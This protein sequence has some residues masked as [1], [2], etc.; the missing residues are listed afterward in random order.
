[1]VL[2]FLL[3]SA[4]AAR[5]ADKA[6]HAPDAPLVK[7]A[8]AKFPNLTRAERALLEFADKSNIGRGE[9][10][11]AGISAAPLDPSNDP[12]NAAAW[13]H[14]RDIRAALLGWLA[15]DQGAVLQV[16]PNGVRVLG[17]R[18]V[19]PIDF[20]HVRVPF[21]IALI[22]CS[23]PDPMNLES[24]ELPFIDLD[25]SHTGPINAM[26]LIVHGNLNFGNSGPDRGEFSASGWVNLVYA[27]IEGWANFAGG[28]FRYSESNPWWTKPLKVALF[29]SDAEVKGSVH[30]SSGFES[31][32]CAF[33]A[34]STIGGDLDCSGGRFI[35][36]GNV[37]LEG[38][39][40]DIKGGVILGAHPMYFGGDFSADGMVMFENARVASGFLVERARFG[41]KANEHH[42]FAAPGLS[43]KIAFIWQNVSLENGAIVDL[44][45]ANIGGLL[46]DEKSWPAP[47]KLLIDG[48]TYQSF[49]GSSSYN[50]EWKSPVDARS[51]LRWLGLQDGYH[52]QPYRQ[53]AKVLREN[54]DED[55][56]IEVLVAQQDARF[57]NSNWLVRAWARF[58]KITVAYGHRPLRTVLWSLAVILLGRV[59]V[60]IG[61]RAGVM[62][63][64]WPETTPP[65]AGNST[66]GLHPL[67]YSL[68]VFL[69]FV[70][71]H[72]E[73]Y[74]WPDESASGDYPFAGYNINVR[75]SI[76]R[77]YL[78]L[79]IIAGWLLSA[80]FVA[81]VTGLMRND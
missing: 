32:G 6:A 35:N 43:M 74:W 40:C 59:L 57:R 37:A 53:L 4:S 62:R 27:K 7:L 39:G 70:N 36:P 26:N 33:F 47:G 2:A 24:A 51:R 42:G 63:L 56:A 54:G 30:L 80:I 69:P 55:G 78:W 17:A 50:P 79:Q 66:A 12:K 58:L 22:R 18:I 3:C 9:F 45:G 77:Y 10:A 29:L 73:Q 5:G 49:A 31:D 1:V 48:L 72:Q 44:S 16:H 60:A 34:E 67:L 71:L 20:A 41:G 52:P 81:G 75:G 65:P 28:H 64:T 23:V 19:G 61:A 38:G 13:P 46:D 25:G 11:I 76:L 15:V 8:A 68:D 14:D 21:A